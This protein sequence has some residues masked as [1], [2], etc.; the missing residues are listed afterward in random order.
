MG[1][2]IFNTVIII[3]LLSNIGLADKRAYVWTYEYQTMER[4]SAEAEVYTTFLS[5]MKSNLEGKVTS[6]HNMEIE[7]GMNDRF[8]VGLYQT[9]TQVPQGELVYSGYKI[10][11]RYR[12]GEKNQYFMDPLLYI[13]Y[14][15]VPDFSTHVLE[16]KGILARDLGRFN[17]A[18][19]PTFELESENNGVWEQALKYSAGVQVQINEILGFGL[20]SQ[21]SENG[22][23]LGPVISHGKDGLYVALG[24]GFAITK[25]KN[26]Q[27]EVM[28]RLIIGLGVR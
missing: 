15:G 21:G 18:L 10:R 5:P 9:F 7:I 23:Y 6:V 26:N 2:K 28:L 14:Q 3:S 12:F 4:G 16:L 24:S 22:H 19:N 20:E 1:L 11:T 8:D 13:E 17:I 27:P 25:I